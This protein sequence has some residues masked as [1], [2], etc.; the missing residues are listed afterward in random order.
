MKDL[1]PKIQTKDREEK[2]K[3]SHKKNMARKKMER[4]RFLF[5]TKKVDTR[6]LKNLPLQ[7]FYH[8]E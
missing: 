3:K 6:Y 2:R 7:N 5:K 8:Q 1:T 4:D